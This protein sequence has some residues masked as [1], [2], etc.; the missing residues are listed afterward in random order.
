M[1]TK[2]PTSYG[3]PQLFIAKRVND[4]YAQ[5]CNSSRRRWWSIGNITATINSHS[6]PTTWISNSSYNSPI[7]NQKKNLKCPGHLQDIRQTF[8]F[9]LAKGGPCW[10]SKPQAP[11]LISSLV[12]P[13]L[14]LRGAIAGDAA[15]R[16]EMLFQSVSIS[17]H[18]IRLIYVL[19][20]YL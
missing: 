19:C 11:G 15:M 18:H 12:R 20:I 2:P 8:S 6:P 14:S 17:Y 9:L 10:S 4:A 5:G 7:K 16:P 3:L 13:R 1:A